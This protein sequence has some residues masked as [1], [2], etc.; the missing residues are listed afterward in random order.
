MYI[1]IYSAPRPDDYASSM[2]GSEAD[3]RSSP[4]SDRIVACAKQVR[5]LPAS[6][7]Y[8]FGLNKQI[9]GKPFASCVCLR[10][11][12]MAD[13]YQLAW[14]IPITVSV[15]SLCVCGWYLFSGSRF[16]CRSVGVRPVLVFIW[17][18]ILA[19]CWP[20][21]WTALVIYCLTAQ[22]TI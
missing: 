17:L 7:G 8:V 4:R 19:I 20:V 3:G 1:C 21:T 22:I 9:F 6:R 2:I 15:Y 12:Y 16:R 10:L 11:I 14:D 18:L 5:N 13:T